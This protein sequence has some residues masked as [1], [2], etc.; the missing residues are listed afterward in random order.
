M[1]LVN[2]SADE[3]T[4]AAKGPASRTAVKHRREESHRRRPKVALERQHVSAT[5]LRVPQEIDV[6]AMPAFEMGLKP[7]AASSILHGVH[8]SKAR[9]SRA[10]WAR[11]SFRQQKNGWLVS[12]QKENVGIDSDCAAICRCGAMRSRLAS[13]RS[14][15]WL[16]PNGPRHQG[17]RAESAFDPISRGAAPLQRALLSRVAPARWDPASHEPT[18][19]HEELCR[20]AAFG[21]P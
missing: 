1:R 13:T 19:S 5:K 16:D 3:A 14:H 12:A 8:C 7:Q 20:G 6:V 15:I 18:N 11:P 10:P 21:L 17:P 9:P 4:D 2:R